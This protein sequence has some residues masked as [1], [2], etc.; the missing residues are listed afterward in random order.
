[1]PC[2]DASVVDEYIG[3]EPSLNQLIMMSM[4]EAK[5]M[6]V[7]C[8]AMGMIPKKS[9]PGS[10]RLIVDLSAPE[11]SSVNDGI[12]KDMSSLSYTS[13]DLVVSRILQLGRG[14]QLAKMDI[15]QMD[16][17]VPVHPDDRRLL[18]IQW[19]ETVYVDKCLPFGLR[20]APMLFSAVADALQGMMQ[21]QGVSFVE[22]CIDDFVTMSKAGSREC[23]DNIR[24]MHETC[25]ECGVPVKEKKSEGL[26]SKLQFLGI[27]INAM[28]MEL[29][30]PPEKLANLL[31]LLLNWRGKNS[32]TKRDLLSIIDSLSH[33]A[34]V[35]W[36]GCAFLR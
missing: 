36:S 32:C 20:S 21:L 33:A 30:L 35:I 6:G 18:G 15:K 9:K 27:E 22:N 10:W 25:E 2:P 29:S 5:K 4:Q 3:S 28:A 7:Q 31:K 12:G 8:S 1:M 13:V 16:R 17:L 23:A 34:K 19:Q 11:G 24:I 26:T 14:T